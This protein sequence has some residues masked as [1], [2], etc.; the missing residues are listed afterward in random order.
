MTFSRIL[1]FALLA[2]LLSAATALTQPHHESQEVSEKDGIPVLIKHL[3]EWEQV[4]EHAVFA[5]NGSELKAVLGERPVLDLIDFSAGTEAVT[6]PYDA[7]KLLIVEYVSP[8]ASTEADATFRKA[9]AGD[10]ATVYRRIGNY[11]AFVFDASDVAAANLLLDQVQYE[12]DVQWLGAN[13]FEI[14][15]ERAFILRLSD[16]FVSTVLWILLGI[17]VA[18]AGG[19]LAGLMYFRRSDKRRAAMTTFS[20]AGGMTRLN[21]DGFTPDADRLLK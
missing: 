1:S 4:R 3:P 14:S 7:G 13:P 11:N 20:D 6:A 5:T 19:A 21:L 16:I 10:D 8:Q 2:L 15:A 12:K 9:V 18:V 17:G